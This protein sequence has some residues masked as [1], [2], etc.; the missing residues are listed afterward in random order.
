MTKTINLKELF[1]N[2]EYTTMQSYENMSV[3]G[4]KS[5]ENYNNIDILPLKKGL[6]MGLVE[7]GEL[8]NANVNTL[9]V[10]NNAITPLLI[11]DGEELI[12]AKQNRIA[13]ATYIIP[14]KTNMQIKVSCTE[15]GRWNYTTNHFKYSGHFAEANLRKAKAQD[16]TESLKTNEDIIGSTILL[17]N[18]PINASFFRKI[19]T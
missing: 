12:G 14:P 16:V 5:N 8:E 6:Q 3:I 10:T 13:N 1:D 17:E 2:F 19:K 15:S 9:N 7:I 11:L 4:I 18:N